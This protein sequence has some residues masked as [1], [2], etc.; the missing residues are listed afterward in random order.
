MYVKKAIVGTLTGITLFSISCKQN[1]DQADANPNWDESNAFFAESTLPYQTADFEKIKNKDFKPAILEGMRR[2]VE[3]IDAITA[4]TEAPT[5]DNTITALEKS[6]ALL[7]RVSSVFHLLVGA[8]TN[9]EIKAINQELSPKFAAHNDGIYLNDAL[10]QRVKQLHDQQ[11]SLG[12]TSEQ[13]RVL[14]VYYQEFVRSGANLK[15]EQKET[16]KQLNQEL[17]S[18]TTKFGDQLLAATKSGSV[19]FTKEELDGL[20]ESELEAFKQADGT[21]A[22]PLNNTTQQPIAA[23]LHK[24]ESR[25]KLFDAGW[26]R[27]EKGDDNDTRETLI[28]IAKKRAEKAELLGFKNYAEWSLQGSMA[29]KP[30]Q[31]KKLMEQLSPYAVGSATQE[32]KEIQDLINKEADPFTLTAADWDYYA[33]KIREQ[34]YALNLNEVK[35]YFEMNA[36]LEHGVFFMAEKLYG[37][38]FHERKDI[39]VWQEDVRV[40]EIFNEDK[41]PIGLFY[42][43]FYARESKR[44]GAWMSNIV[45]QSK[46]L[47]QAPVVYNVCNYQKPAAGQPTLLSPDE[48][49]TMFHEFG[50]G[51]HGFLSDVT[52]PTVAGTSVSRDF[53]ELPSQF[54]EHFAF[55]PEVLTNYAKHY[56][57]GEVIPESLIA[58]MKAAQNFNIGYGLTEILSAS[59]LDMEWHTISS[60]AD[61]KDVA[62]FEQEALAKYGINLT[63]VPPRYRSSFFNH[64]FGGGYAAG[65]YSYTW[66]ETLDNDAFQWLMDNGGMNRKNGQIF[67]D[68]ILS[69]GNTKPSDEMYREFRGKDATI[70]AYLKMKG[71]DQK[72]PFKNNNKLDAKI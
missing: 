23:S 65:Y 64:V 7:K 62:T 12:L 14:D 9:D 46:L 51:L 30:D 10:F 49:I 45:T 20:S 39:P 26:N 5:F 2:Q 8:H 19:I 22:I 69:K 41:S 28:T 50:H 47:N 27:T 33:E 71:F 31:A 16:L 59:L 70:D 6:S 67:R 11:A 25:K 40:F 72:T 13:A 57:T 53:V 35:P 38:T 15:P 36:V 55:L 58:K 3:A 66:A 29:K 61:I 60:T 17:A 1:P 68:K 56:K 37:I 42:V 32:A 18:L 24:K 63:T 54:H 44:G 21:Y 43:D 4:N 34:K 48:V 52:Y